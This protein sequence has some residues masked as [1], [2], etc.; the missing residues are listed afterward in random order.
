MSA[1]TYWHATGG[2]RKQVPELEA[3]LVSSL[4]D[5]G[6]H[7]PAL[8]I[9]FEARLVPSSTPGHFHLYLDGLELEWTEYRTLLI[10]LAQA[11]VIQH[12]YASA[13]IDRGA[14]FLRPPGQTK[15]E[16]DGLNNSDAIPRLFPIAV[17]TPDSTVDP[18]EEPF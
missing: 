12:G 14:T 16:G 11:G 1:R 8:D 6:K 13:C 2:T 18:E 7:S 5:N 15:Y 4:L 3:N 10:A 17:T 9:D